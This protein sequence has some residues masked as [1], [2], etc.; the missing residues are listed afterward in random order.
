MKLTTVQRS[1]VLCLSHRL[2]VLVGA[3]SC[4]SAVL[5][6]SI[7]DSQAGVVV[8][9]FVNYSFQN[10][11][12]IYGEIVTDGL[13]GVLSSNDIQSNPSASFG[14]TSPYAAT[15]FSI[16]NTGYLTPLPAYFAQFNNL[17]ADAAGNLWSTDGSVGITNYNEEFAISYTA[18]GPNSY[19]HAQGDFGATYL[20]AGTGNGLQAPVLIATAE[21][22]AAAV[23]EPTSL[24]IWVAVGLTVVVGWR[25]R[26]SKS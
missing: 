5:F 9:D 14:A 2:S 24:A 23:P 22:A 10:H 21:F 11:Y 19:D 15:S 1:L 26:R 4:F 20:W 3:L 25:W 6:G 16:S 7:A 8:Y 17:T 12:T 13:I 18:L